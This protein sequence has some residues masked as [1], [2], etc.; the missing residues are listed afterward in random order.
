M[1]Q[2]K[3]LQIGTGMPK[4]CVPIVGETQEQILEQAQDILQAS[5][6][7]TEW[8]VDYYEDVADLDK[9]LETAS[10]LQSILGKIPLLFT[11]RTAKEGGERAISFT[12]YKI[13]LEHIADSGFVD[14]IDVEMFRGYDAAEENVKEWKSTDA[15]N[16]K[17]KALVEKISQKVVVIGSYHD[18]EKTP[19]QEEIVRRLLFMD[20]MNAA[21]PKMAVMPQEREDVFRLMTATSLADRLLPEKPV[22]T[23]SMGAMGVVSRLAGETF[24]SAVT[25]GCMGK[26]SAP[27]QIEVE[28]LRAGLELLHIEDRRES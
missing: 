13:L 2:V 9:V 16:K 27:G 18:F 24:G 23:M 1:V 26:A 28:R 5:V 11:F 6:D 4:I 20:G 10:L 8:R 14:M 12:E 19:S 17:V 22:I 21:I 7:L 15:C 3:S 25:F